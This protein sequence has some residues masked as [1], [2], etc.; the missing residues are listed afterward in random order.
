MGRWTS[1]EKNIFWFWWYVHRINDGLVKLGPALKIFCL[2][3]C[4]ST[5]E[6]QT[7]CYI[8]LNSYQRYK[9]PNAIPCNLV[10]FL[11]LYAFYFVKEYNSLLLYRVTILFFG[12]IWSGSCAYFTLT[13]Y[14]FRMVEE[15]KMGLKPSHL[16]LAFTTNGRR[17]GVWRI[18]TLQIN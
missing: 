16:C 8:M 9:P 18:Q 6:I 10:R 5:N 1:Y 11:H 14:L 17:G 12:Q 2:L 7:I 13:L 15:G 4:K 3:F